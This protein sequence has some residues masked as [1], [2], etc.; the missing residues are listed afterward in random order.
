MWANNFIIPSPAC[1]PLH[2]KDLRRFLVELRVMPCHIYTVYV[3]LPVLYCHSACKSDLKLWQRPYGFPSYWFSM[4]PLEKMFHASGNW[5]LS[6]FATYMMMHAS[7]LS[8]PVRHECLI[9]LWSNAKSNQLPS[10]ATI[11][12]ATHVQLPSMVHRKVVPVLPGCMF[13]SS[14]LQSTIW[15]Q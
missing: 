9:L 7:S 15:Q 2:S 11:T 12:T 4:T 14:Y 6:I 3:P 10:I 8:L 5:H 13:G 1:H